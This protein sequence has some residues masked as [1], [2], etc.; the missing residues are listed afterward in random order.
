LE[1][2]MR[3]APR[4]DRNAYMKAHKFLFELRRYIKHNSRLITYDERKRLRDMALSGDVEGATK[5]LGMIM[6]GRCEHG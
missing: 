6:L 1:Q 3:E 5:A 2:L 4:Y